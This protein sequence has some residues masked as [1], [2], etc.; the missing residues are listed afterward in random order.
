MS[1]IKNDIGEI[2]GYIWHHLDK[3]GEASVATVKTDIIKQYKVEETF[4]FLA[5]GW[6]LR[7]NNIQ[8][9]GG[10]NEKFDDKK[11]KLF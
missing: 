10:E 9:N 2:A 4:F 11:I 1:T 5:I 8:I 3:S 6:L 7:E